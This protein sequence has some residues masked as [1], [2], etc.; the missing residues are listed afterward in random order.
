MTHGY[1]WWFPEMRDP[2]LSRFRSGS[3]SVN[4]RSPGRASKKA[5]TSLGNS[6]DLQDHL[7]GNSSVRKMALLNPNMLC[8]YREN[9]GY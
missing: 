9:D 1:S 4:W 5:V 2:Q 6:F 8:F 3:W 7:M